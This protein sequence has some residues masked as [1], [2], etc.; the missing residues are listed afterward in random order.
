MRVTNIDTLSALL[1]RLICER[2]KHFFFDKEGKAEQKDH[3]EMVIDTIK[4]KL[5]ELFTEAFEAKCYEYL[6]EKRTFDENKIIRELDELI[7][8]DIQIGEGDRRRL[9]EIK[10]HDPDLEVILENE[11]LTRLSNEGRARNKNNID[12]FY[13]D[14]W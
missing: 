6:S 11:K 1:D 14:L 2:I 9:D 7:V 3:Q 13:A 8:N 10:K 5:S 4:G 12:R